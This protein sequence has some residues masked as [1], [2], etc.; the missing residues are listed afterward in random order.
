MGKKLTTTIEL[1]GRIDPSLTAMIKQATTAMKSLGQA[2]GKIK[3]ADT[4][5]VIKASSK[6]MS[7][8]GK[9]LSAI[10]DKLKLDPSSLE[11]LTGKQQ[12]L[13][14]M[15][16]TSKVKL[17]ALRQEQEEF[18]ASGGDLNSDKYLEL[19]T[20]IQRCE[21]TLQRLNQQQNNFS[22]SVQKFGAQMGKVSQVTE[23]AAKKMA[24]FSAAAGIG[25]GSAVKEAANFEQSMSQVFATMGSAATPEA[26]ETLTKLARD[27]GKSTK[28]SAVEAAQAINYLALAGYDAQTSVTALPNILQL[29]AAGNMDLA[30]ASDMVTDSMSALGVE[31]SEQSLRRFN[32]EMA[33]A[34]STTNTSVEQLGEAYL[35]I[36]GTG[37]MLKGGTTE[38]ATALGILADNGTKGAEGGTALRNVLLSMTAPTDQA[39]EVMNSL[40]VSAFDSEGNMRKFN[41]VL[42]DLNKA[43]EPMTEAQR[44]DVMSKIFNKND[45]TD[46]EALLANCGERWDEVYAGLEN[47]DGAA[48]KMAK[49]QQNN[50]LGQLE[51][52]SGAWSDL[53]IE[54]GNASLPFIKPMVAGLKGVVEWFGKLPQSA[55]T[56]TAG[57]L[58]IATVAAPALFGISKLTGGIGKFIDKAGRANTVTGKMAGKMSGLFGK[59]KQSSAYEVDIPKLQDPKSA[60]SGGIDSGL[61]QSKGKISSF[62]DSV[63][64]MFKSM[65]SGISTAFQGI[66]T[67][68]S[69]ALKGASSAIS[70]LSLTGAGAFALLIGTITLSLVALGQCKDTVLPFFQGL[71]DILVSLTGGILQNVS[72]FIVDLAGVFPILAQSL[73]MLS[74]LVESFGSAISE[75]AQGVGQGLAYIIGAIGPIAPQIGSAISMI[76]GSISSGVAMIA[77]AIAQ[78]ATALT[79]IV[80]TI[81]SVL[82]TLLAQIAPVLTA[83]G[84]AFTSFGQGVQSVLDGL[85]GVITSVG[86]VIKGFFDGIANVINSVGTSTLNAGRGFEAMGRGLRIIASLNLFTLAGALGAIAVAIGP[87]ALSGS[88]MKELGDGFTALTTSLVMITGSMESMKG[89]LT[90]LPGL[91]TNLAGSADQMA[92]FGEKFAPAATQTSVALMA[93]QMAFATNGATII[94]TVQQTMTQIPQ[95]VTNAM[96]QARS[97]TVSN[98]TGL[99]ALV[100]ASMT[101]VAVA[102]ETAMTRAMTTVQTGMAAIRTALSTSITGPKLAVPHVSVSGNFSLNPPSV[103]SFSVS[104]FK[105]GGILSGATLFGAMGN[106]GLVGG[107]AGHEAVLPLS[108]LWDKMDQMLKSAINTVAGYRANESRLIAK[109][110]A[111]MPKGGGTGGSGFVVNFAP[112]ININGEGGSSDGVQSA[113]TSALSRAK[114]DLMDELE[115]LFRERM[116]RG[117]A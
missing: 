24:P 113:V 63:G 108:T 83:L 49:E 64:G 32:D 62:V 117:Y 61:A 77:P 36:G 106:R 40:G 50:L 88:G 87:L 27:Q 28:Y 33:K 81:G 112:V 110:S 114:D 115:D 26:K 6:S 73:A 80:T 48:A 86:S 93:M 31:V 92:G 70:G 57:F 3:F 43:L 69:T 45:L 102:F 116:E 37:K 8:M 74:P 10:Q 18:V 19:S 60:M 12:V 67:G 101:M 22:P 89:A 14:R 107:E 4:E 91:I 46:I 51:E 11:G 90:E 25:L 23:T 96:S 38:L 79:P 55:K 13:N 111:P 5:K 65:G 1:T 21:N 82:N 71:S 29:A 78:I 95:L 97:A 16:E 105:D 30:K 58:G 85:S 41:D 59:K 53:K 84:S 75:I 68:I 103:P 7:I 76:V 99:A 9:N 56:A 34:S 39:K 54:L 35:K 17:V 52:L 42:K 2:S 20:E 47:S 104:Y 66:G 72:K 94:S 44:T 15:I 109:E 98:L 100:T